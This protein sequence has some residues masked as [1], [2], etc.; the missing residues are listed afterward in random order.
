MSKLPERY[1]K[2]LNG[3]FI[4]L[5]QAMEHLFNTLRDVLKLYVIADHCMVTML[6][7]TFVT[8]QFTHSMPNT[9]I[10]YVHNNP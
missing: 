10:F 4:A 6:Y 8:I 1:L 5:F 7:Q 9:K 3:T 2:R